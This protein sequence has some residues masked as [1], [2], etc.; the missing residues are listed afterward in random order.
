MKKL[1]VNQDKI[2]HDKAQQLV[3]ICSFNAIE[4]NAGVISINA[5]C[6]MCMLCVRKGPAGCIE[7]VKE[8]RTV[9]E[10]DKT[11]WKGVVVYVDHIEGEIHP[12]TFELI[13]KA[14]ELAVV[15]DQPVYALMIGH[16]IAEKSK[17]LLHYGVDEVFVYDH[18]QLDHFLIEP[19]TSIFHDYIT[20]RKP[21]SILVGATPV[22]RQLA[23][24]VAA[25]TKSGLTADCTV[26]QMEE[27]TDLG[28]IRPAFGGNIMAEIHT[29]N[30]RP[31][32]ATVRYKVM[33]APQRQKEAFGK[34]TKCDID[35]NILKSNIE[36]LS[37]EPKAKE[38]TIETAEVIVVAGRGVKKQGDLDM[39]K[40]LASLLDAKI[41][42]TR[43]LSENGWLNAKSQI[44]L[45][46]RTVRPKL[47]ITCGVS[48]TIQFVSGMNNSDKIV[49][50]NN[51]PNAAIFKVA[52]YGLVGDIYEIVPQL[53]NKI[54][55]EKE[56]AL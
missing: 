52:H 43:P 2:D 47:I 25:R 11:A 35:L 34:I 53:I 7:L 50:I 9:N 19:Y 14:R 45:S 3:D 51:D 49:A 26:L 56:V 5:A 17:E 21:G 32:L 33:N 6:K 24:R 30:N 23:A 18:K 22:G 15:I 12:I 54:K 48:G 37:V 39:I 4:N 36:V 13:G 10:V 28:Q 1:V 38:E 44:G 55:T 31:Q 20:K 46:G 8:E 16:N 29:P 40:E 27:N 41:A 42:C